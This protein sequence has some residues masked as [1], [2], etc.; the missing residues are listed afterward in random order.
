MH[1]EA[2]A[3]TMMQHIANSCKGLKNTGMLRKIIQGANL[4]WE[5]IRTSRSVSNWVGLPSDPPKGKLGMII[6]AM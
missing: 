3:T 5:M 2:S 6:E 1:E 4:E